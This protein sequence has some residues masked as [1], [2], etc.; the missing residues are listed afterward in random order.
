MS[1]PALARMNRRETLCTRSLRHDYRGD[2]RG[3]LITS[4]RWPTQPDLR[5]VSAKLTA[6]QV[7]SRRKS[8]TLSFFCT[9]VHLN[10]HLS[11]TPLISL[12]AGVLILI[13]PKLLNFIVAVYLIMIGLIGLFGLGSIRIS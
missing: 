12:V 3:I 6:S 4:V 11:L 13:M 5:T 2:Y 7:I 9:G 8:S 1:Y 10:I